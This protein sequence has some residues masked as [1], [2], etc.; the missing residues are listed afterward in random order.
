MI[1]CVWYA[2]FS[3]ATVFTLL[4]IL[5]NTPRRTVSA[6]IGGVSWI[7]IGL[8]S[9]ELSELVVPGVGDHYF[10]DYSYPEMIIFFGLLGFCLILFSLYDTWHIINFKDDDM[11]LD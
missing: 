2:I 5:C 4:A 6:F 8:H 7:M 3:F 10:V 9:T 11:Y 1:I